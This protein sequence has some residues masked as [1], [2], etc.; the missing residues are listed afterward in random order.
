VFRKKPPPPPSEPQDPFPRPTPEQAAALVARLV[1]IPAASSPQVRATLDTW[2]DAA[3]IPS[4]LEKRQRWYVDNRRILETPWRWL[5][6]AS[7]VAAGA[8]DHL[9]VLRAFAVAQHIV[10]AILPRAGGPADLVDIGLGPVPGPLWRDLRD[11]ARRSGRQ[12]P[13]ETVV[14][15]DET[16]SWSAGL[17]TDWADTA[18][19]EADDS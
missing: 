10:I 5:D 9:T 11:R 16:A 19:D 14:A 6:R 17:V 12:L 3:G 8:G 1:A 2:I 15:G 7:E 13:P 18:G 4:D